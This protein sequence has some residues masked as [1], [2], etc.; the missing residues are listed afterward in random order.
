ML[1]R[2]EPNPGRE[3]TSR[4]EGPG[5]SNTRDQSGRQYR[6]DPGNVMKA[7]ARLVG[8]VP[9]HDH[10]IKLQDLLLEA[11]QLSAER[12]KARTGNLRHPFVAWVG[13]NMQQ[14]R[15]SFTPDRRDNAELGKV[16]SDRINHRGLLA[17]EQMTGAVKHQ[18]ALLLGCLC[19]HEPHAGS[20][21]RLA[22]RFCVSHIVLLP[23]DVGL[24]VSRRHQSH[25][26]AKCLQLARPMV[27]R[28]ASLDANQAWRQLLKE[29]Q[30]LS[31]LQLAADDHLAASVNAV[32]LEN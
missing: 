31:T 7:L 32:N 6:T 5:V 23:F 29:R 10:P 26:M 22:N 30:D 13:N 9:G 18:A 14:F 25:R 19:W 8:P 12:G 3:V 24:H 21:D 27:R 17:D 16:R 20:S 28:G 4:S 11:K 15:D 1:L 2:N